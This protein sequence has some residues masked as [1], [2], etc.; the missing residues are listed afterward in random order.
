[1]EIRA[2]YHTHT[3]F[4]HGLGSIED[5]VRVAYEKG[6][7]AVGITDHGPGHLGYGVKRK[8]LPVM[9]WEVDRLNAIY[10]PMGLKVYLGVEANVMGVNGEI[11]LTEEDKKY[12]DYI[13]VGYHYGVMPKGFR[14]K[15]DF[16]IVNTLSKIFPS[17][18][19]SIVERNTD[20]LIRIMEKHDIAMLTHPGCKAKVNVSRLAKR[21]AELG[22]YMEINAK[23]GQ[24]DVENIKEALKTDCQFVISS[25]AHA[26][27]AVGY[28]KQCI[29]RAEEAGV[30]GSRIANLKL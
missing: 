3:T 11:D 5:N 7:E 21:A 18:K 17:L 9:R 26:P 24:L 13:I 19:K 8:D 22:V 30:P 16:F 29:E 6:L 1:M 14:G 25:D 10:E 12:L 27:E 28:V 4:S 23:H 2:D 15:W 20:A